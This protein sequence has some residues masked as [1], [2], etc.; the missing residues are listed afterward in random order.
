MASYPT[1]TTA[2]FDAI[3]PVSS[4]V[5]LDDEFNQLVGASGTLNGGGTAI[6]LKVRASDGTDAVLE[7]DQ[8]GA[9]AIFLLKQNTA[10]KITVANSGQI[11]SSISTGTAPFSVTSTTVCPNLN[12]DLVDGVEG[13]NIAK[14]DTHKTAWALPFAIADPSA[15]TVGAIISGMPTWSCPDGASITVTKVYVVY[16]SGSHTSGGSVSFQIQLKTEASSWASGS[17]FGTVTLD[18]TNATKDFVYSNNISDTPI[19]AGDTLTAYVSAR[20]GTVTERDVSVIVI[21]TQKFT[22]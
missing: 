3:K 20:S 10:T 12:A 6:K 22:T 9:G 1:R 21:G 8:V 14:L 15:P 2:S 16:K 7:L 4:L 18:N 19:A 5:L 13:A 17:D 11:I